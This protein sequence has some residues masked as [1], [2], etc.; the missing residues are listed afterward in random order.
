[1]RQKELL[2]IFG[3]VGMDNT[4]DN[5]AWPFLTHEQKNHQLFLT[6]KEL[7]DQFLKTGA[8]SQAQHDKSLHD[9]IEKM[10][11]VEK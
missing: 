2:L 3:G 8:I 1:M 5:T 4:N 7:L 6:Q 10:G 9:L 11:G